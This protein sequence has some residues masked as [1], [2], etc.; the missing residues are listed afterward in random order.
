MV[1]FFALAVLLQLYMLAL[2]KVQLGVRKPYYARVF[3]L[4]LTITLGPSLGL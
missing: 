4:V 3:V 1:L 2:N